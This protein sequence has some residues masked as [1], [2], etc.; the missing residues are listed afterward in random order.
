MYDLFTSR[1]AQITSNES[2]QWSPDIYGDKIV[3][4]DKRNSESVPDSSFGGF[5][6]YMYNLSTKEETRI[7]KSTVPI[8][9]D[10]FLK[11]DIDADKLVWGSGGDGISVYNISTGSQTNINSSIS[12]YNIAFSGDKIA[13]TDDV[14]GREGVVYVYNLSTS[15]LTQITANESAYGG[16][17]IFGNRV[18]WPD[19]RNGNN[20]SGFDLY[21]YD[22]SSKNETQITTNNSVAWS[23]PRIYGDRIVWV[24]DR[25]VT[26]DIYMYDLANKNETRISTS[27]SAY[28]PS[29]FNDSIGGSGIVWADNRYG[30]SDIYLATIP[31][32]NSL[33]P[34]NLSQT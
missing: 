13:G 22:L 30:N 21:M 5:D 14:D 1:E 2:D 3:W 27:G 12:L 24:D 28:Q 4:L 26:W 17:G 8:N 6:V 34:S 29:I 10:A 33:Y 32:S 15:N 9:P 23:V 20:S 31:D 7:S 25:N 19:S 11:V 18:V 16:P